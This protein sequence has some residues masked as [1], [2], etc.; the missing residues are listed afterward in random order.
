MP[1]SLRIA[2]I[3]AGPGLEES[4]GVPGVATELLLGLAKLGHRIDCYLPGTARPLPDRIADADGITMIW[5]TGD[6]RWNRW[7]NRTRIGAFLSGL[8]GR[9]LGSLR[10][11]R[12]L[13]R[14]HGLEPY[15]VIYQFSSIE[16]LG[17]PS[18]LKHKVPLV[19]HPETHIAGELHFLLAERGLAVRSQPAHV[20]A[21]TG[22]MMAL[23]VLVQRRRIRTASLLICISSVFRD[24]LLRD[25]RFPLEGT[26]VIPNPVRLERFAGLS[27]DRGIGHP[28]TVLVLG[29]IAARKGIEDVVAMAWQLYERGID[30]RIR[31]VG[32]PSLSSDYTKLLEDLPRE[33]S[34]Y[35]GRLPPSHIPAELARAVVLVQASKYEPFGLTVGEALAA[36]VPVVATSEVGAIEQ[37]DRA[38]VSEVKPGDVEGLTS[39][40]AEL[41]GRLRDTPAEIRELARCEAERRFAPEVV[42]EQISLAL[43]QLIERSSTPGHGKISS[44]RTA[45]NARERARVAHPP[46]H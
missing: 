2:W 8:I 13:A 5:G 3:G 34:E 7:Y 38:V 23:R 18:S 29:R 12:G 31:V 44:A 36:G 40:V 17:M 22:C 1:E 6:W 10:L 32:G 42:C 9:G 24:H 27:T 21:L 4:G 46:R 25:Y 20:T 14:R 15:D 19:I 45:S 11:R 16:A 26:V 43:E 39:A 41:L 33:N 37:I 30:A 28:P 35:A